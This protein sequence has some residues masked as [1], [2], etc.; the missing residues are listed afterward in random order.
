MI[1]L[2]EASCVAMSTFWANLSAHDQA[3][4]RIRS[5]E[6]ALLPSRSQSSF[7]IL[8]VRCPG[9]RRQL[10]VDVGLGGIRVMKGV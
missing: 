3:L 2:I 8:P 7:H 9:E 1:A 5:N 10:Y 4:L 6:P